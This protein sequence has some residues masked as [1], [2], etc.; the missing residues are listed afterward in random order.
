MNIPWWHWNWHYAPCLYHMTWD[1]MKPDH[2]HQLIQQLYTTWR[3]LSTL[4]RNTMP[5]LALHACSVGDSA[6]VTFLFQEE[7]GWFIVRVRTCVWFGSL[8]TSLNWL[9]NA[10]MY[11]MQVAYA[12]YVDPSKHTRMT[13]SGRTS[14]WLKTV[15]GIYYLRYLYWLAACIRPKA[16]FSINHWRHLR[17]TRYIAACCKNCMPLAYTVE[18]TQSTDY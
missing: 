6:G 16:V 8:S 11:A 1:S 13:Y 9:E 2:P 14:A 3:W 10:I 12:A 4:Q 5:E 17:L 15:S 7:C 18:D